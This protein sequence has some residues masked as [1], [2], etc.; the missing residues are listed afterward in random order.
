MNK[1]ERAIYDAK[2]HIGNLERE[3]LILN[4]KLKAYTEQLYAL[5]AIRDNKQI[6]HE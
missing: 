5:E 1:I 3:M 4:S 2:L 6:K